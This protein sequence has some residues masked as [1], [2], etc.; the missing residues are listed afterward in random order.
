[1]ASDD[2]KEKSKVTDEKETINSKPKGAT[3]STRAQ[4]IRRRTGSRSAS[5]RS[6][7]M[8]A[9]LLPLLRT[10]T[11]TTLL[12]RKK[13]VK[14]DYSKMSF[15]YSRITYNSNAHLISIPLGK[16]PHLDREDYS[17][18]SHKMCSHLF[19]LHPSI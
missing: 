6:S 19:S 8:T 17:W 4:T 3:L 5:R 2:S 14:H 16:P 1:M 11:T 13:M 10:R 12:Q 15:N 18:W 7:T 9:M